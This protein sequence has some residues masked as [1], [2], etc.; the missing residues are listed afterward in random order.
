MAYVR[1]L[2]VKGVEY[3]Q[4][5]ENYTESNKRRL[6]VLKSFG[7][8]T[9]E[10][11]LLAERYLAQYEKAKE[12]IK[13]KEPQKHKIDYSLLKFAFGA[14]IGIGVLIWLWKRYRSDED[15]DSKVNSHTPP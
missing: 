1:I 5:A 6:K 8:N 3:V 11:Y 13:R 4:V 10:N 9:P 12:L 7:R 15:G 2:N 14:L